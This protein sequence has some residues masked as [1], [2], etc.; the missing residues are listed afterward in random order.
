MEIAPT[1]SCCWSKLQE[2]IIRECTREVTAIVRIGPCLIRIGKIS[3]RF[4]NGVNELSIGKVIERATIRSI[5][6]VSKSIVVHELAIAV[7]QGSVKVVKSYVVGIESWKVACF[8]FDLVPRQLRLWDNVS[9]TSSSRVCRQM[10]AKLVMTNWVER[11]CV[12]IDH[13]VKEVISI[14]LLLWAHQGDSIPVINQLHISD[15]E[16]HV[17]WEINFRKR[18]KFT[19]CTLRSSAQRKT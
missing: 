12:T 2:D 11:I 18:K 10:K 8:V 19:A 6:M 17:F 9:F 3:N 13:W 5:L 4:W 15:L 16:I 14:K 7:L 1:E